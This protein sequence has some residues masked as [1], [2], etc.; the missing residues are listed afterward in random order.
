MLGGA[1]HAK[2]CGSECWVLL[3]ML[4]MLVG[5]QGGDKVKERLRM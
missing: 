2:E 1:R 3:H 4:A 5:G